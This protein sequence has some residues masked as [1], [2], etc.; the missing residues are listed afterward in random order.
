MACENII[1]KHRNVNNTKTF[2]AKNNKSQEDKAKMNALLL[3]IKHGK[4]KWEVILV[5]QF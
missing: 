2:K 3:L 5:L 4:N 1:I